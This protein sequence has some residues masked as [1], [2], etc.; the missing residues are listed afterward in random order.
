[1]QSAANTS[2]LQGCSIRS[3][4]LGA[5]SVYLFPGMSNLSLA[6]L[7]PTMPTMSWMLWLSNYR[8]V[9]MGTISEHLMIF[10]GN[11]PQT[12]TP[13]WIKRVSVRVRVWDCHRCPGCIDLRGLKRSSAWSVAS[14]DMLK[15]CK[16]SQSWLVLH[17]LDD[18][19]DLMVISM[20]SV[21]LRFTPFVWESRLQYWSEFQSSNLIG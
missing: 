4:K 2:L 15:W 1:M 12:S 13:A 19:C 16:F 14:Y 17:F 3:L 8:S 5:S 21:I 20:N 7:Q 6:I 11:M 18:F 9:R 10:Q